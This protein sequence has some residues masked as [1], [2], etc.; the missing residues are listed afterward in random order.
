MP[1]H[2]RLISVLSLALAMASSGAAEPPQVLVKEG[3]RLLL[4]QPLQDFY[5]TA[6]VWSDGGKAE[7]RLIDADELA[8]RLAGYDVV[9]FGEHHRHPG[10]H[11]QQQRLLRALQAIHPAWILSM[12]QFERDVQGVVDDYLAGKVGENAL[13]ENGRAW[14]NYRPSYRPLLQFAKDHGLP[15]VAAE[16]PTW[17]ISCIGQ[18]GT[19]VMEK[20]TPEERSWVA[21][22]LDLGPGAYR[23]KYMRFQAGA[24]THGGGAAMSDAAKLRAERS[25]AAQVAR[26][27]TM[28][29]AIAA[30]I[31]ARP[32][33]KVLHL[34]GNFHS[35]AFLGTVERLKRRLPELK[36]A[37]IDPQEV[38]DAKAPSVAASAL[39]EGTVLQ[40]VYPNPPSFVEGE[41]QS[42]FVRKI[43]ARRTAS[44]CKYQSGS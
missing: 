30:A 22:E 5:D 33:H 35:A 3:E 37:V 10:V 16:A 34:D 24:A 41:D 4:R 2:R 21:R 12:E 9:F 15:V 11:L 13:V 17:A 26:D 6:F 43:M 31:K 27:E 1:I 8:R 44:P 28:A 36:I 19:E 20:F 42:A 29:E 7:P 18:Q 38:V 14:D 23:D 39:K 40:L 25:Y 32:G